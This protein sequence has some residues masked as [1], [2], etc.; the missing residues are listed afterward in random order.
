MFI[1][2]VEI[3]DQDFSIFAIAGL[4]IVGTCKDLPT[5]RPLQFQGK[6]FATS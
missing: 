2:I 3:E 4:L 5:L 6:Q 1:E